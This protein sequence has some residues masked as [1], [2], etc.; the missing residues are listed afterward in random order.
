MTRTIQ[1]ALSALLIL[2]MPFLMTGC[3]SGSGE[4]GEHEENEHG[5]G[6]EHGH[7]DSDEVE[8]SEA[9]MKAVGI[10]L[11][12][13]ESRALEETL[14]ANG[15]LA[16]DP[17]YEAV[18][19]PLLGGIVSKI[20]VTEGQRVGAGTVVA[21][22]DITEAVAL[23]E[24]LR[25]AKAEV[26]AAQIEVTRQE[27]LAAQGAGIR[28]NLDAARSALSIASV[29]AQGVE[30]RMRQYGISPSGSSTSIPV[31]AEI[32]GTVTSIMARTG[33]FADMQTPVAKIVDNSKV[34]C[35]LKVFE[36]DIPSI[37]TGANVDMRLTNNPAVTF[38]GK[39]IDI[40]PVL[41]PD[42]KTAPVKVSVVPAEKAELIPG[43]GVSASVSTGGKNSMAMPEGAIVS[44]GGKSYIFVLEGIEEEN[45]EKMYHFEKREVIPG[46]TSMGYVEITPIEPLDENSRVV[47]SNAFF[48]GSM[49]TDHGEHNH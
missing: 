16:I 26:D 32:S 46:V 44:A 48:L 10:T 8:L 40:N 11:G 34:Y 29:K 19:A 45:G 23:R 5:H 17:Q 36:K 6:H 9:Q 42:T 49:S 4:T 28:K 30:A 43:M 3:A 41:E 1:R 22:V 39:I 33:S 15:V 27:A 25:A 31:K 20:C 21:Y 14:N 13:P 2:T 24:E 37:H 12:L 7:G 47:T 18:A 35:M 38:T